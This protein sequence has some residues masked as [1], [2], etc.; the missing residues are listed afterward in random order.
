MLLAG[1]A[2]V[3]GAPTQA[4]HFRFGNLN[5]APTG[6]PGEVEFRLIMAVRRDDP[7][8]GNFPAGVDNFAETGDIVTNQL[9]AITMDYGDG[10]M[11]PPLPMVITAFSATENW[12]LGEALDHVTGQ[13]G[14]RHTYSSLGPFLAG[15]N[16][17]CR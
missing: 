11:T 1:L 14:L 10:F 16:E 9:G 2:V 3:G 8:N 17:C 4:S 6:R 5:W 7:F 12:M 15:L 13:R